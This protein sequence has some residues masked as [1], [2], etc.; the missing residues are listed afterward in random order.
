[1]TFLMTTSLTSNKEPWL[2]VTFSKIFPGTGQIYA[3][4]IVKGWILVAIS[5]LQ[6]LAAGW[7]LF[8]PTGNTLVAANVLVI[9]LCFIIWNLFDAHKCT[10]RN[11]DVDFER[12]R[13]QNKDPWLAVFL[14][15]LIPGIGHIY[16]GKWFF[17]I[18]WNALWIALV[19]SPLNNILLIKLVSILFIIFVVYH[20]YISSPSRRESSLKLIRKVCLL[21]MFVV[22]VSVLLALGVRT[23]VEPR[24]FTSS[25]MEPTLQI[26]DRMLVEKISYRV[27]KPSRGEIIMFYPPDNPEI[28][29]TGKVNVSVKRIIGVPGDAISI[30]DG[31]VFINGQALK[32]YILSTD[33]LRITN[34]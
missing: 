19:F 7:F 5:V 22:V 1:M 26:S 6:L 14:S 31:K 15:Q 32:N 18:L 10:R 28:P 27:R 24:Y 9:F 8:S 3:G 17:A 30:R 29:N 12:L 34:Q 11:N 2:A 13:R 20:A 25:S 16:L 33:R 4:R 23:S 21:L